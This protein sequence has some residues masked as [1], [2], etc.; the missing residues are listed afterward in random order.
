MINNHKTTSKLTILL[1]NDNGVSQ[2][3]NKLQNLLYEKIIHIV[4]ITET[5]F[6]QKANFNILGYSLYKTD[7][8]DG[9]AHAGTVILI[10]S[11][12]QHHELLSFQNHIYKQ[13][14][15]LYK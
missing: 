15:F 12:I 5:Y 10:Y 11:D 13:Q 8:P 6:T 14:L 7:Y 9:F 1:W 4:L 3:K 2:H